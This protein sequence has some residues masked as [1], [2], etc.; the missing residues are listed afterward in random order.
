MNIGNWKIGTKLTSAFLLISAIL[1]LVGGL[2]Y[3]NIVTIQNAT[4]HIVKA[5]PFSEAALEMKLSVATDM[6]MIMELLAAENSQ[7]LQEVWREHEE[8]VRRFDLYADAIL[9][10]ATIDG[11]RFYATED[12]AM[13]S[14]VERA[15]AFH[16][17]R[18]QPAL[19]KIKAY[20]QQIYDQQ[21]AKDRQMVGMEKAFDKVMMLATDFEGKV[22]DQIQ[23]RLN[24]G[25]SA[26]SILNTENTW[27]DMAM[28]IKT[29][30][31]N[32]RIAIEELAQGLD[33]QTQ[34]EVRSRY[35]R[36]IE[37]FDGWINALKNGA[38]T[39]EGRVA[40][41]SDPALRAM[42]E[43]IDSTHDQEF[44]TNVSQFFDSMRELVR[45]IDIRS[46]TDK[47]AD[48]TGGE[49]QEIIGGVEELAARAM[50]HARK[51]ADETAESAI[52]QTIIGI[53]FGLLL[54]IALGIIITRHIS[55]P[56]K[57]CGQNIQKIAEGDLNI[58]CT[59]DRKDE[60][61]MIF[62]QLTQM[63]TKLR[64]IVGRVN[65]AANSVAGGSQELSDSS[66][67]LSQGATEQAASIEETS[68]AMEQMTSNIQQNNDNSST[69]EVISR[70]AS[71]DAEESGK[72]VAEATV[73]MKQIAE[74]IS[75]IE[76]IARQTNLL[77]LNAAIEA[78]RAGEHGKGF[79]VVA[80]E[81]RKLA[82][83][84][85]TAAGEIGGL[86]S[87]SVEI[88]EKAGVMLNQ[89]VP[90]I[91]KTAELV[92]EISAGSEEQSQGASQINSAIQQLDMVI[93]QNA[94]SA[95]EMA[96]TAEELSAQADEL[97]S[98]MSFFKVGAQSAAPKRKT[99]RTA[100]AR[101]VSTPAAPR[102]S[103]ARPPAAK[104]A[105][106]LSGPGSQGGASLDMSMGD[107]EFE[108]F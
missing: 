17:E 107:D 45:V 39:D 9:K 59:L 2:G 32:S 58:D 92:Q 87:S 77:A 24:S 79:A 52:T 80:A 68:S 94:G 42:V 97:K 53:L 72:A 62:Q 33:Q 48:E 51:L 40:P 82:E 13:R 90:D 69:T 101:S 89:L 70:K 85:Q 93:Q 3:R 99:S 20:S 103:S 81:V 12:P 75:I 14:I 6:Q 54:S 108:R 11:N 88:A 41:V 30:L 76:E 74:K 26:S 66:Q 98:V 106:Q 65:E 4:D 55:N 15:D 7:D 83:R 43:A 5:A 84:S 63:T 35:D 100:P 27:A 16:N 36:T 56:L 28:E 86:S 10:G 91:Q 67:G 19:V 18:F 8:L 104:P 64:S 34:S 61:G 44:Q 95:E 38:V 47:T 1:V 25:A 29:T 46:E 21:A 78:A 57:T 96:G 102:A 73:A 23:A 60:L 37:E 105:P 50:E 49:M 71:Q 31:A 22:K